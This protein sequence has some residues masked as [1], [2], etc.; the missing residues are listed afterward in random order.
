MFSRARTERHSMPSW[1]DVSLAARP[2]W[3]PIRLRLRST[4][5]GWERRRRSSRPASTS[6]C[7]PQ[8]RARWRVRPWACRRCAVATFVGGLVDGKGPDVFAEASR[9]ARH[10][11]RSWAAAPRP[12]AS[13]AAGRV[14]LVGAARSRCPRWIQ[15][16]DVVVIRRGQKDWVARGRGHS[17]R[18]AT[19]RLCGWWTGWG[20][21]GRFMDSSCRQTTLRHCA[22][23]WHRSWDPM[24]YEASWRP[25]PERR[26]LDMT[27]L[28]SMTRCRLYGDG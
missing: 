19:M 20:R 3:S 21:R 1:R 10:A 27:A 24:R 8:A 16:A 11:R 15:A 2:P 13:R 22:A 5:D 28:L 12:A 25:T 4:C 14:R 9:S 6:P 17:P 7:L 18:H 23:R 26:S